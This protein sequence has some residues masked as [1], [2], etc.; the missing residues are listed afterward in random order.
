[1]GKTIIQ[2]YEVQRPAEAA[3]ITALGVDH[4]GSVLLSADK[5]KVPAIRKTVQAVQ[6][7]GAASVLIP[8]F[9]DPVTVFQALDYY[10]PDIVHFCETLSIVREDAAKVVREFDSLLSF[11]IDVKDR[12][13]QTTI[14]RSLPVPRP[15]AQHE[16]EI[17]RNIFTFAELLAP[18]SDY[19]LIDTVAGAPGVLASQPVAGYIGITGEVGDWNMAAAIIKWSP[20]PVILAGGISDENAYDAV[21]RL[22]P[23]GLDSCTKTN[24]VDKTGRPVRFKKDLRKV[25]RLV[26]EVRRADSELSGTG[27]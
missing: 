24:A 12:F 21:I 17:L 14:M 1:M 3:A 16:I 18:F 19:F 25:T 2:I 5:W 23:A 15:G 7:A 10:R 20:I 26:A 4:V 11:Q 6:Q 27:I 8:L 13:P 9:N 22:R